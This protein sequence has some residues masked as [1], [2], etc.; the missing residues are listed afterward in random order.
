MMQIH[1]IA[2]RYSLSFS[3][4]LIE[5]MN[6]FLGGVSKFHLHEWEG[7]VQFFWT[8]E[9]LFFAGKTYK[10][11][12]DFLGKSSE[13]NYFIFLFEGFNEMNWFAAH[14]PEEANVG[15]IQCS[16]WEQ[17][18]FKQPIFPVSYHLGAMLMIMKY[19][20][21]EEPI[22]FYHQKSIGCMFDFTPN[23]DEVRFKLQSA[24]ICKSCISKI[25]ARTSNNVGA[26]ELITAVLALYGS[27]K[28]NLFPHDL[29]KYFGRME[30]KLFIVANADFVLQIDKRKF[31]LCLSNGWGKA[32][33][34]T[35]LRY[36]QGL[37]Y[38][39]FEDKKILNEFLRIYCRN[40]SEDGS[41][42]N[43]YRLSCSQI[44][45][46]SFVPNLY[47]YVSKVRKELKSALAAFPDVYEAVDIAS[48][49]GKLY[50]P[51]K[52]DQVESHLTSYQL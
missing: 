40:F 39:D 6:S 49:N 10:N 18:D 4:T 19:F 25:S 32:V 50:I 38:Q 35:L 11:R 46:K 9:E 2:D 47:G 3:R 51:I 29:Q 30:Y 20:G 16:G 21:S 13:E 27:V 52:K 15:F 42:D 37:R 33:Y 44:E 28:E 31:K 17:L 7:D 45:G 24:H 26:V 22:D 41:I 14:D 12:V 48:K 8:W 5:Y 1:L 36:P 43:L 34:M 23:K